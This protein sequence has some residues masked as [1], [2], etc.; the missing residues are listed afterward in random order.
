MEIERRFVLLNFDP[1][2]LASLSPR[3][4]EQHYLANCRG[5]R[6]R[7]EENEYVL[8]IKGEGGPQR[9]E[10]EKPL[11]E[12]DY[13]QL[14]P[15]CDRGLKKRRYTIGGWQIDLFEGPLQGLVMAEA[16][17][18]RA[19]EPLPPFPFTGVSLIEVTG[20]PQFSNQNLALGKIPPL[21]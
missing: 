19:D 3:N 6:I 5:V 2:N 4:I 13:L 16:E 17:L 21:P 8:T 7:K 14:L 12:E 1:G 20:L 15:L 9:I 18:K 10:V 11:S